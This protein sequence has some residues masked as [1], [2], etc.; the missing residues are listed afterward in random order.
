M[1]ENLTTFFSCNEINF[2]EH[3]LQTAIVEHYAH[4]FLPSFGFSD[5][6]PS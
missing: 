1:L 6:L 4:F 2:I 3:T 5:L